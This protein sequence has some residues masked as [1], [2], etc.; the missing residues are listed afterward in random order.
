MFVVVRISVSRALDNCT[1]KVASLFPILI[2]LDGKL[3]VNTV[4][5]CVLLLAN[6]YVYTTE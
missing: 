1:G 2:A 6:L 5:V 3:R 4:C